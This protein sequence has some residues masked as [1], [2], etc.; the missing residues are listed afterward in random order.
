MFK[1]DSF[2]CQY[3]GAA[4]PQVLLHV[5]HISPVAKG[6]SND[7]TNLVTSCEACNL[8]KRDRSLSDDSAIEKSRRQLE[9]LQER[10][11][12]LEM[13]MEWKVGLRDLASDAADRACDYW[14]HYTPGWSVSSDGKKSIAQW[15]KKFSLAEVLSAMDISSTQYLREGPDKK[16]T[17][18]SWDIAFSKIP[19]ICRVERD[20]KSDPDLKEIFYIR[21]IARNNCPNYFKD[22]EALEL[23]RSA[24]S[25]G[26]EL[27]LLRAA[28]KRS[29]SWT[30]FSSELIDLIEQAKVAEGDG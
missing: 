28:A 29:R 20:S 25:W 15:I 19:G 9:E 2:K 23:I 4:A 1:R 26:V 14:Q 11:E 5:D 8:G 3:C 6:G 21:G 16:V 10:R 13:M 18:E 27:G 7:I 30:R 22:G 12:Q 17:Q 24:R